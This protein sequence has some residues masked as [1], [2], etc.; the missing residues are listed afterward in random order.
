MRALAYTQLKKPFNAK[1]YMFFMVILFLLIDVVYFKK[2]N[3]FFM[4]TYVPL[5]YILD[6]NKEK[7]TPFDHVFPLSY[8]KE[9]LFNILHALILGILFYGIGMIIFNLMD[10]ATY[11]VLDFGYYMFIWTIIFT[12]FFVNAQKN[13]RGQ[14]FK[15]TFMVLVLL[16]GLIGSALIYDL[17]KRHA[18]VLFISIYA[19][20][21]HVVNYYFQ[22]RAGYHL[23]GVI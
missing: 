7:G 1:T 17:D 15:R 19:V 11:L 20:C 5:Q 6:T 8:L 18:L 16:F 12:L 22:S 3:N 21:V 13:Y 9:Y 23:G 14:G 2:I 10:T 4:S